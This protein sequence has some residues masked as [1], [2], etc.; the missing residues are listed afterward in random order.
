MITGPDVRDGYIGGVIRYWPVVRAKGN[1]RVLNR[2]Q[3]D[4]DDLLPGLLGFGPDPQDDQYWRGRQWA[5]EW[6]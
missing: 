6:V 5:F 3:D 4:C 1:H 2:V